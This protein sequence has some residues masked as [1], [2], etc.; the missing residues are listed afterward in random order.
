MITFFH[1]VNM[2][3]DLLCSVHIT[4]YFVPEVASL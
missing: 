1:L 2:G 4:F 3:F